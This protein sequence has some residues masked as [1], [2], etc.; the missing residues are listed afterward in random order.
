MKLRGWKL[1]RLFQ[2]GKIN[3]IKNMKNF[4]DIIE[5]ILFIIALSIFIFLI[6]A[7][8]IEAFRLN[9]FLGLFVL[10]MVCILAIQILTY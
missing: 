4:V 5:A 1:R 10:L 6:G 8:I 9:L 2:V 7:F 3:K